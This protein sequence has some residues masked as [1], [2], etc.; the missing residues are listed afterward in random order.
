[1]Y[2]GT[3]QSGSYV[4]NSAKGKR[5][6]VGRSLNAANSRQKFQRVFSRRRAAAVGLKIQL[7]G[8]TLCDEKAEVILESMEF[9]DPV[10]GC[11]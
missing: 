8:D 7:S 6:R 3:L 11:Y 1:M 10:I 9:P 5:E 2:S 4:K